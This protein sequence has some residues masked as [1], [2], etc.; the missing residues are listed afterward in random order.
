MG[1]GRP[2]RQ[3]GNRRRLTPVRGVAAA[4]GPTVLPWHT[5]VRGGPEPE[6]VTRENYGIKIPE[7]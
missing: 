5:G 6:A 7:A 2:A 1:A 3:R 4:N